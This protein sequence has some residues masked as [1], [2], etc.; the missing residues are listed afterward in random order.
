MGRTVGML[1]IVVSIAPVSPVV[2][3]SPLR[4]SQLFACTDLEDENIQDQQRVE[5]IL[6]SIQSRPTTAA[7]DLI[8][9]NS[10][11]LSLLASPD[12]GLLQEADYASLDLRGTP[13]NLKLPSGRLVEFD[14][15]EVE[16]G[17]LSGTFMSGS[18]AEDLTV[19][20]SL[21]VADR[22]AHGSISAGSGRY[23]VSSLE[24]S[25]HALVRL[26]MSQFSIDDP[27]P[28]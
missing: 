16:R 12:S 3:A 19:G 5:R 1:A 8:R 20:F 21:T 24:G 13:V 28:E 2:E 25:R 27:L 15:I 10:D 14:R 17:Q 26:D 23:F 18:S 11:L 7:V 22:T 4:D 6:G 9:M